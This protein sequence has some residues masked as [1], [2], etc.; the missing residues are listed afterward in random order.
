[1]YISVKFPDEEIDSSSSSQLVKYRQHERFTFSNQLRKIQQIETTVGGRIFSFNCHT[2]GV[3]CVM[4]LSQLRDIKESGMNQ[5]YEPPALPF[6]CVFSHR[7]VQPGTETQHG[8]I[9]RL[10]VSAIKRE[11]KVRE[12]QSLLDFPWRRIAPGQK[13]KKEGEGKKNPPQIEEA[14]KGCEAH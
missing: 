1:M 8:R 10:C 12:L 4:K 13:K 3:H 9:S 2:L 5:R 14:I 7:N 11:H 6:C